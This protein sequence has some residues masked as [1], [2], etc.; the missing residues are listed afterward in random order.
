MTNRKPPLKLMALDEDDLKV[1][2][3][4]CQDAVLRVADMEFLNSEN[5]FV[6]TL[7]RFVWEAQES[8]KQNQSFERR[9]TVLH[10]ERV[11]NV[12][13]MGINRRES[14]MVLSL[15]A[16][17][18]EP[19]EAPG[20]KIELVFA[21]DGAIKLNV[22]CIEAQLADMEAAWETSSIPKHDE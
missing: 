15:L 2:S 19:G 18:F 7:N 5:R 20:G 22:E 16:V 1:I 3:A 10:F 9:K 14:D 6:L 11:E 12:Q 8:G 21:G 13:I 17:Q 4:C